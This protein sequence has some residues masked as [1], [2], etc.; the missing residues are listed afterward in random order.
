MQAAVAAALAAD[1]K[2]L[3]SAFMTSSATTCGSAETAVGERAQK[4]EDLISAL[5]GHY[6]GD[7]VHQDY[8]SALTVYSYAIHQP[9]GFLDFSGAAPTDSLATFKQDLDNLLLGI[10]WN[11]SSGQ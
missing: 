7:A 6:Y 3:W 1:T 4:C 2:G 5:Y 11:N 9:I 10:N 8:D